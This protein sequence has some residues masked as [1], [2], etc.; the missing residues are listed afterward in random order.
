MKTRISSLKA[1]SFVLFFALAIASCQEAP[2][3]PG[4]TWTIAEEAEDYGYDSE[5]LQEAEEYS[6]TIATAAVV[7]VKD[8]I[9]M[10]EWGQVE[11]TGDRLRKIHREKDFQGTGKRDCPAY[12]DGRLYG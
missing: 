1:L 6:R 7:I 5:K 10:D 3:Y 2:E 8:G 9:I 4:K 12:S 11:R